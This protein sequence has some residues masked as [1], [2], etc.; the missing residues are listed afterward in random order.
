MIQ[1]SR[2]R[3]RLRPGGAR[4]S[5]AHAHGIVG[6]QNGA[7]KVAVTA[8]PDKGKANEA[9]AAVLAEVL[10]VK[11]SQVELLPGPTS[12]DK[13]FLIRGLAADVLAA[14]A[15]VAEFARIR[16]SLP[17]SGEFGYRAYSRQ[18]AFVVPAQGPQRC[19]W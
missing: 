18:P 11:K 14:P 2:A 5:R 10:E 19:T 15:S 16:A 1:I 9:I 13:K 12:R 7:L 3:R 4:P 17:N 6:E 8:P